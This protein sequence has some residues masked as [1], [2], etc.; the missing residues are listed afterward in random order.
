MY[1]KADIRFVSVFFPW[2]YTYTLNRQGLAQMR[3]CAFVCV[4]ICAWNFSILLFQVCHHWSIRSILAW[5]LLRLEV[6]LLYVHRVYISAYS[7]W[8]LASRP[9]L[10]HQRR[11]GYPWPPSPARNRISNVVP[12]S[13]EVCHLIAHTSSSRRRSL[14]FEATNTH[15][16]THP[17]EKTHMCALYKYINQSML[18]NLLD[19]ASS[20]NFGTHLI[21]AMS[22]IRPRSRPWSRLPHWLLYYVWVLG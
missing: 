22:K 7:Y 17:R 18:N 3:A 11:V 13:E 10:V 12:R 2:A 15:M 21:V 20:S 19:S 1:A 9:W 16:L 4:H 5:L 6:M 8:I 14:A